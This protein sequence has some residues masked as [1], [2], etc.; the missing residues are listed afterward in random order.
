MVPILLIG[1]GSAQARDVYC[2]MRGGG[3]PD[4]VRQWFV[5]NEKVRK[6]QLPGRKKPTI[7][8]SVA[9][10]SVG[11]MYRPIELVTRPKLGEVKIGHN[12]LY[13]RSAKNG[14]DFVSVRLHEVSRTGGLISNVFQ[15]RIQ[16]VDR[17]L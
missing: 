7:G 10:Q 5:V 15:Y 2:D 11:G 3:S 9:F 16:V 1:G 12:R 8:C 4:R 14:E 13:Y 6:P 17:P